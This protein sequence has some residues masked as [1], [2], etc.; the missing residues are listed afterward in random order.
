MAAAPK[1]DY[2]R[3]EPDWRAGIKSVQQLANEYTEATG[4][5]VSLTSINKHFKQAKVPRDLKAKIKA[6]AEAKVSAAMVSGMGSTRE[7]ET[8]ETNAQVQADI[9]L[10]H[11][12]D[13]PKKRELVAKLFAEVEALTDGKDLLETLTI[14]L[15]QGDQSRLADVARNIGSLPKRIKGVTDLVGA[16]KTLIGLERQVFG[17]DSGDTPTTGTDGKLIFVPVGKGQNGHND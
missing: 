9:I 17:I 2:D 5:G 16:Y 3:I 14:A 13:I 6:M 12:T 8:I 7:K 11:R 10:S 1:I 4:V 15:R